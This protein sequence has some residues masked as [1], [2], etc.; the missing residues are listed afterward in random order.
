[1]SG[2]KIELRDDT[3]ADPYRTTARP[4]PIKRM[5]PFLL[6]SSGRVHRVRSAQL[7]YHDADCWSSLWHVSVSLWCGGTGFLH[8]RRTGNGPDLLRF[9]PPE[10]MPICATC[11]GRAV[12]AGGQPSAWFVPPDR[13]L[14]FTPRGHR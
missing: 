14:I 11:E 10:G 1:M 13:P 2:V 3:R 12:G 8:R 4:H 7:H 9:E 6:K 5:A